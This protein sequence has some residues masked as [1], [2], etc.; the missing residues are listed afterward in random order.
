[1]PK[2][3]ELLAMGRR[4]TRLLGLSLMVASVWL[5]FAQPLLLPMFHDEGLHISRAQQVWATRDL[6]VGTEGGK[7]LQVW[8]LAVLLPICDDPLL[9]ARCLAAGIGLLGNLGCF[10]L[11]YHLYRRAEVAV[12]AAAWYAVLPY[13]LFFDRMGLADGLLSAMAI[14][15]L[16]LS[17]IVVRRGRWWQVLALGLIMGMA[18]A[19]KLSGAL[20]L[21]FPL[22]A[23]WQWR[24]GQSWRVCWPRLLIAWAVALPWLLPSGLTIYPQ[25][26][27]ALARSWLD[28]QVEGLPHTW[29]LAGNLGVI[30]TTLWNYL[31]P[32]LTVL[33]LF[34]VFASWHQRRRA[35]WLLTLTALITVLFFFATAAPDKFYPRYLL[36]AFPFLLILSAQALVICVDGLSWLRSH[37]SVRGVAVIGLALLVSGP[38][39]RFDYWLL[40][41]PTRAA[42]LAIDRWQYINGWPAGYGVVDAASYLRQQADQLGTIIVVRR[43]TNLLRT[44][45]WR[46]YLDQPNILLE[47]ISFERS[48]PDWLIQRLKQ[49][50]APVFVTLDRPDE[51]IYAER[52]ARGPFAPYSTLLATFPRP[53]HASWIEIYRA[54]YS[55]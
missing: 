13:T 54:S 55:P 14:W 37:L 38:A 42:W 24:V 51:D 35:S 10:L 49:A 36:P 45:S 32:P 31:T 25:L 27:S 39:I 9:A 16:L 30:G 23:A 44:G 40:T 26:K 28:A 4:P 3:G 48:D 52:F 29:R 2:K 46:H 6:L 33:A 47:P 19:A 17:L 1:M 53:D 15:S 34:E 50:P 12:L 5:R 43:A 7:Y 11:A 8:L 20:C 41:D 18:A 21:L 22:L